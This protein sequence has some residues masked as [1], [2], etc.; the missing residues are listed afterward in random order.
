M[1]LLLGLSAAAASN[2]CA[3]AAF[4]VC[5]CWYFSLLCVSVLAYTWS[6]LRWA[7]GTACV[8]R[9]TA[10]SA[11]TAA[12]AAADTSGSTYCCRCCCCLLSRIFE[13]RSPRGGE[14]SLRNKVG[15]SVECSLLDLWA[16]VRI[17]LGSSSSVFFLCP[18]FAYCKT[19]TIF[20]FQWSGESWFFSMVLLFTYC[21]S[22]GN[23]GP[24]TV[25]QRHHMYC[26]V[27]LLI[28]YC[29]QQ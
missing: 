14:Y 18:F 21:S 6:F 10:L 25:L 2:G 7:R 3:V 9:C 24:G 8:V 19:H 15:Q 27:V 5:E 16:E 26:T 11:A 23:N 29:L 4:A 20:S 13:C 17:Y 1:L 22:S 28:M 12:A